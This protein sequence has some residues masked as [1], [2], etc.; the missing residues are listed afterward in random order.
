M[1]S[2]R[3]GRRLP[4]L[5]RNM[6]MSRDSQDSKTYHL[7]ESALAQLKAHRFRGNIRELRNILSR[8][9]VLAN[10]NVIDQSVI[11]QALGGGAVGEPQRNLSLKEMELRYLQQL[12]SK[13]GGDREM[14]ADI[15]GISV[16]S[17]YRKLQQNHQQ[18]Q[19]G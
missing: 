3:A 8:A 15:A 5:A 17:L 11:N 13:H 12:M 1:S 10:T 14:V 2:Q 16:R 9:M 6:L 18:E 4:L 19:P 7:T